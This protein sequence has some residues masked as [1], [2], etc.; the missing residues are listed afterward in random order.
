[1]L[2]SAR[3]RALW[4]PALSAALPLGGCSFDT[5]ALDELRCERTAHCG[6]L[7]YCTDAGFCLSS[8]ADST[9]DGP[10]DAEV[11]LCSPG[12]DDD[13]DGVDNCQDN[14]LAVANATQLD[15]DGDR[16]GNECDCLPTNQA[17]A[18]TVVADMFDTGMGGLVGVTGSWSVGGGFLEQTTADGKALSWVPGVD[19]AAHFINAN[20]RVGVNGTQA[21][22]KNAAGLIFR[23]SGLTASAG[24]AYLCGVD[25]AMPRTLFLARA[26][27]SGTGSLTTL[28]SEP[29][30]PTFSFDPGAQSWASFHALNVATDG[31]V[32]NCRLTNSLDP[33]EIVEVSASDTMLGSGSAGFFTLGTESDFG[34]VT[35]CGDAP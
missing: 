22:G 32:M 6:P 18:L 20:L 13:G 24:T 5:A 16:A 21:I 14:C 15:S 25:L 33:G 7:S 9:P 30:M 1:M 8:H 3:L 17:Y 10:R 12:S 4:I 35:A 27:F 34:F 23:A 26:N 11:D 31:D 29:L 19:S 28:D 2:S